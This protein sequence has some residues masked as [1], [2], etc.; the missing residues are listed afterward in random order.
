MHIGLDISQMVYE[1]TGV[2][3]FTRGLVEAL[4]KAT[5][6]HRF[7]FFYYSLRRSMP[8][9]ILDSITS[10]GHSTVHIPLP[11]RIMTTLWNDIHAIP[12]TSFIK[13]LDWFITSDWTEPPAACKKATIVHDLAFKRFPETIDPHILHVMKKKLDLVSKESS[14][15][16]ADSE[17]TRKDIIEMYTIP[18]QQV[19]LNYPGVTYTTPSK[20]LIQ[21]VQKK[22]KLKEYILTVGKIEPRKNLKRLLDAY[23]SLENPDFELVVIGQKGWDT[24]TTTSSHVHF[25]GYVSDEELM[26]LYKGSKGFI[27]PSLWEGFGYPAVEAMSQG[28]PVALSN[29]SSLAEIGKDVAIMFNPEDTKDIATALQKLMAA[30]DQSNIQNAQKRAASYTWERYVSTLVQSLE[31]ST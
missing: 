6:S 21:S 8:K 16:F 12:V 27:F 19:I 25:L 3:R 4:L 24:V 9:D 18:D 22:Y 23:I 31:K 26:A 14:L 17:A 5:S 28:I 15:I 13:D 30:P 2:A 1:G 20:D 10:A 7:T 11:P 29:R